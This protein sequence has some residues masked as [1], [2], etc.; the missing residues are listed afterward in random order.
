MRKL[1]L[2][3]KPEDKEDVKVEKATEH[4]EADSK[5]KVSSVGTTGRYSLFLEEELQPRQQLIPAAV[6]KETKAAVIE[7]V[8]MPEDELKIK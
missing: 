2:K 3:A 5:L 4:V 7:K 8:V 6:S 1:G